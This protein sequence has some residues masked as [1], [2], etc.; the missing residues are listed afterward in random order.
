MLPIRDTI[1]SRNPPIVVITIVIVN[2]LAFLFELT[3]P[4]ARLDEFLTVFGVVPRR[5]SQPDWAAS[6][7]F[8][9]SFLPFLTSM[10]LHGGW[11]HILGNMW[12]LW[13]FGDNIED[14]MGPVRFTIFYLLC[15]LIAGAAHWLTNMQSTVPAIGAS[16]AIAG[17]LGA[18]FLM[19]PRASVVVLVPI[20]LVPLFFQIPAILYLGIWMLTQVFSGV[21]SLA[22]VEDAA[23]VAWWA[24]IGGFVAG[25]ILG[26]LFVRGRDSRH[27]WQPDEYGLEG[28]WRPRQHIRL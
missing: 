12:T 14:R 5:Y 21:G 27:P 7:G 4:E 20:V 13:I 26:P 15:G 1:P 9:A 10:F 24:H 3:M 23:G 28:A 18:Y 11:L 19:F 2:A 22:S 6:V 8:T 17:V 16:G 25:M